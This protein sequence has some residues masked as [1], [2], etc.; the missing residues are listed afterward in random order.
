MF[1]RWQWASCKVVCFYDN[2]QNIF[3]DGSLNIYIQ[4]MLKELQSVPV[5]VQIMYRGH[6][7]YKYS[8]L[9]IITC[10]QC[11]YDVS[12]CWLRLGLFWQKAPLWCQRTN[13]MLHDAP[14]GDEQLAKVS[15]QLKL[16]LQ[17]SSEELVLFPHWCCFIPYFPYISVFPAQ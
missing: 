17:K 7:T 13:Y 9:F 14:W 10:V 5:Q 15:M 8:K 2:N 11:W 16:H 6:S 1:H 3:M 12:C 4:K